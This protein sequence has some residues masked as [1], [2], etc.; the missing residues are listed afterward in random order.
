MSSA[1]CFQHE[2]GPGA[3]IWTERL[4]ALA[5]ALQTVELL[6][7]RRW[8][9]DVGVWRWSILPYR[10]FVALLALRL[11]LAA[12]LASGLLIAAPLLLVSHLAV[13]ARFRGTFNG[14]SDYM[15]S[16]TLLGL[17]LAACS[18]SALAVTAGLAYICVQLV[19][20]YF[21]AG[22]VKVRHGAWRNGEALAMLLGSARYRA[23]PDSRDGWPCRS[24]RA[25]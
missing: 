15:M 1:R 25:A 6:A 21:I 18:S 24:S 22:L 17:S 16:V 9:S 5:V 2:L 23:L 4:V 8:F 11:V 19:L 20:S 12:A 13:G 10:R 14:G 7:L 3:L